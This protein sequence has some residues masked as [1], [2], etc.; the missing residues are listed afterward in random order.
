MWARI[1][2]L[3]S[4][5]K[6]IVTFPTS[7]KFSF[8]MTVSLESHMYIH[9]SLNSFVEPGGLQSMGLMYMP[10]QSTAANSF[11]GNCSDFAIRSN[12]VAYSAVESGCLPLPRII[13][14]VVVVWHAQGTTSSPSA[15][16]LRMG[17]GDKPMFCSP[18][19]PAYISRWLNNGLVSQS[20][21][22][23]RADSLV[24][25]SERLTVS[26]PG[27]IRRGRESDTA[28]TVSPPQGASECHSWRKYS[29]TQRQKPQKTTKTK[30]QNLD[31]DKVIWLLALVLLGTL[32]FSFIEP[33]NLQLVPCPLVDICL[34]WEPCY[35]HS[36][37]MSCFEFSLIFFPLFFNWSIKVVLFSDVQQSDSVIHTPICCCC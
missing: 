34:P 11:V 29:R 9:H 5:T 3:A 25:T 23:T 30:R 15:H 21:P 10:E 35:N 17:S 12:A 2:V 6:H 8:K 27:F 26:P 13:L 16:V 1:D 32:T 14:P 22:T 24:E 19:S 4:F 7:F 20:Q 37:H 36:V 31:L 33:L 18:A 28:D